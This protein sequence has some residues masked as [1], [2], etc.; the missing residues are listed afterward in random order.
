[1][2][3]ST[4]GGVSEAVFSL[5]AL[6]ARP[7]MRDCVAG[8]ER[9][10]DRASQRRNMRASAINPSLAG[11]APVS[12]LVADIQPP[13]RQRA[14]HEAAYAAC[15]TRS[16]ARMTV[17]ADHGFPVGVDTLRSF[18]MRAISRADLPA[19]SSNSGASAF[20]RLMAACFSSR[21]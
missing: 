19:N 15:S 12:Q 11:H 21:P 2:G 16:R 1:M 5:Y 20:A 7:P 14:P 18:R 17:I 10:R 4:N 9:R 8:L 3:H 13:C 6:E